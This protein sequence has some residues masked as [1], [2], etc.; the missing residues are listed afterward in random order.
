M[1]YALNY[2]I[3][4]NFRYSNDIPQHDPVYDF[5]FPGF[6]IDWDNFQKI[7]SL[8]ADRVNLGHTYFLG[9]LRGAELKLSSVCPAQKCPQMPQHPIWPPSPDS[10]VGH[11][12]LLD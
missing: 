12:Y 10:N 7:L 8:E 11:M 3:Y 6:N 1:F 2:D 9:V 4:V 5:N